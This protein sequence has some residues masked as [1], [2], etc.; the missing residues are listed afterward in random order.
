MGSREA[1]FEAGMVLTCE[2][3]IYIAE[4]GIG[5]RIEDDVLITAEGNRL[6]SVEPDGQ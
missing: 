1:V 5:V 4:E 6:L 2:P 3:G